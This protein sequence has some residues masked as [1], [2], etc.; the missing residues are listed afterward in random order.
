MQQGFTWSSTVKVH[1]LRAQSR[2]I[3]ACWAFYLLRVLL[4]PGTVHIE[5]TR[6]LAKKKQT[7]HY[8][9]RS[10]IAHGTFYLVNQNLSA[11][12]ILVYL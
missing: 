5:G 4:S 12:K 6:M 8:N 3:A 7:F 1:D 10:L 9:R 2:L 11:N